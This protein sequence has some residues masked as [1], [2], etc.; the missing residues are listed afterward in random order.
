MNRT[1][2]RL[3]L[4]TVLTL[5]AL[6]L[7]G[8]GDAGSQ[9]G[10]Q[11]RPSVLVDVERAWS[12]PIAA[13]ISATGTITAKEEVK[14]I[15]QTEGKIEK[16]PFEEGDQ[17][18]AGEVLVQLDASI[19]SAQVKEAE[20]TKLDAKLAFDRAASLYESKLISRQEY[21]QARTRLQVAQARHDYQKV[22]LGYT[23][24]RSPISGVVTFRGARVGDVAVPRSVLLVVA[25][26]NT[27][28][29]EITV[30]ELDVPKIRVG[31]P[32]AIN[33]DA[34]P[35]RSFAGQVRRVFPSG[36]PVS[37][38]V[39]VEVMLTEQSDLLFPGLFARTELTTDRRQQAVLVSNDAVMT[40]GTGETY[41]FAVVDSSVER[42]VVTLG[43]RSGDVSEVLEGVVTGEQ[44]VI[45]GQSA[46][47]DGMTVSVTRERE[48]SA[49]VAGE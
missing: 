32:A 12:G 21:D 5:L 25:D 31:D 18:R 37:R 10:A 45:A 41:V 30:S 4:S 40:A 1:S 29:I 11:R 2:L 7:L 39:K 27:L 42:R 6:A 43:I 17:V 35:G 19:L 8:C 34:Y 33:V 48:R 14:V 22:L 16:L 15:A 46:L 13:R 44:L 47:N 26:L 20:A 28:V 24:I 36:D 9:E 23:T 38:L 49:H 3:H